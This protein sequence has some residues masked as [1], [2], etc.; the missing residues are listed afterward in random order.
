[1]MRSNTDP[2]C[3]YPSAETSPETIGNIHGLLTILS[4]KEESSFQEKQETLARTLL[5]ERLPPDLPVRLGGDDLNTL[6]QH[7]SSTLRR[8][9]T[10]DTPPDHILC[11]FSSVSDVTYILDAQGD[12]VKAFITWAAEHLQP[13]KSFDQLLDAAWA[14]ANAGCRRQ[15]EGRDVDLVAGDGRA[16]TL[17]DIVA[18]LLWC[19]A[20]GTGKKPA[21]EKPDLWRLM[22]EYV[23]EREAIDARQVG[24]SLG[25]A[26]GN[27]CYVLRHLGLEVT[28]HWQYH[29]E[30]VAVASPY[31]LKRLRTEGG[32]KRELSARQKGIYFDAQNTLH[33]HPVRYSFAF[34]FPSNMPAQYI[35]CTEVTRS[36]G[37]NR[38]I[39]RI[40]LHLSEDER[41]WDT[42]VLRM[43]SPGG[44]TTDLTV[45]D[46]KVKEVLG[47][48]GWPFF[49]LFGDWHIESG[50][51]TRGK[52]VFEIAGDEV[53]RQIG[54]QFDYFIL[55]GLQGLG[56][57]LMPAGLRLGS[58]EAG[59]TVETV[60]KHALIQQ[61]QTLVNAG[62]VMHTEIPA[63]SPELFDAMAQVIRG[64]VQSVGL[65]DD[66]LLAVTGDER[67]RGSRFFFGERLY[68]ERRGDG[69]SQRS[70]A[71]FRRYQRARH[72][73][74][75]L[76]VDELYVHG[77]DVD[78]I[79]RRR[80]TR[81]SLRREVEADVFTKGVV[82]LALLQRSGGERW[83]EEARDLPPILS[84][85]GFAALLEFA[86]VF[87]LDR[88]PQRAEEA[89][90]LFRQ[91]LDTGY[92]F[93]R[94]PEV[95]SVIIVPVLWPT[96]EP[97]IGTTGAGDIT[98]SVVAIF[99]GR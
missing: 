31:C 7:W 63:T 2:T 15:E 66:D 27:M 9:L 44:E 55:T 61:L 6:V 16:Y 74:A 90:R 88:Y 56:G 45:D 71:I 50:E 10:L 97:E 14:L 52:L 22:Q 69:P 24:Y 23:Q 11:G 25:G 93:E 54:A 75:Q 65:N 3:G 70:P 81:G 89:R 41:G 1:M 38:V 36:R 73:A 12:E 67:F 28:A 79:V 76:G 99:S 85:N 17:V 46:V 98:S 49:P 78:L 47:E 57:G 60:V 21:L 59:S 39:Y 35:N 5:V 13:K 91:L 84:E 29:P 18:I 42:L 8:S 87:A 58:G 53:M 80:T 37:R 43:V 68:G 62:V 83:E 32:M 96:P 82:I 95:Y 20:N 77:N 64:R 19:M 48:K 72:L 94:D 4:T 51:S 33:E 86:K 40:P 30:P 34:E 92:F 26:A